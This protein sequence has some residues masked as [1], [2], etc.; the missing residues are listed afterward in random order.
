MGNSIFNLMN[1]NSN[2]SNFLA[3]FNQFRSMFSG[4]PQQQVQQLLQSGRM[5]QEQF[6]Q[7]AEQA[8]ELQK[9]IK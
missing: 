8:T 7:L 2:N 3:Q 9:L 6:K 1:S 4:N 5:T